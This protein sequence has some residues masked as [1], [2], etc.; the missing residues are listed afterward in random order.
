MI[1]VE[2]V[3]V[4]YNK[5]TPALKGVNLSV[6]KGEFVGILGLSGS[7]KSTLLKS[8][9]LIVR[10]TFGKISIDGDL[11]T[12]ANPKKLRTIRRKV[13]LIFQDYN[14][15]ERSSVLTNVLLGRLGYKSRLQ[16]FL[17]SFTPSEYSLAMDA[18]KRVGLEE[19]SFVRADRL[20]GG[21][22][23]RVAIARTLCQQPSVILA[24]EPISNLD[25]YTGE[26]V[27]E[28]LYEINKSSGITVLVNLHDTSTALKYCSRIIALKDGKIVFDKAAGD[29]TDE[30][31]RGVY[32]EK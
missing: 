30:L 8:I 12:N 17:G 6:D 4:I 27:M 19:K 31:L 14:L 16:S 7:G 32:E 10:P 29:V 2:N 5:G 15:I 1:H 3:S 26:L 18:L 11:I 24:D 13:G 28:Y 25:K 23:Q 20:S 22:K 21:Q 9:N